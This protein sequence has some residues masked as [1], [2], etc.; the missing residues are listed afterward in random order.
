MC[1]DPVTAISIG[2]GALGAA[3]SLAGGSANAQAAGIAAQAAQA[4]AQMALDEGEGKV[5]Q[6]QLRVDQAIGRTRAAAGAGNIAIGSG[7]PLAMQVMSAQQG[8]TD[9]QMAMAGALNQSSGM[10]FAAEQDYAKQEQDQMA[11]IFGAGTALLRGFA[12]VR[13]L[14]GTQFGMNEYGYA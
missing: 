9:K 3:S 5:Q 14:G 10:H 4:N 1:I 11:G 8:N 13:G 7:S 6:I 12:G 2:S